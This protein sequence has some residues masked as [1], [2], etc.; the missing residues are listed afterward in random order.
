MWVGQD[1]QGSG[2]KLR[3]IDRCF[4]EFLDAPLI[5]I[6]SL[7]VVLKGLLHA[8]LRA[9]GTGCDP[10]GVKLFARP[11]RRIDHWITPADS[12]AGAGTASFSI[13][14]GSNFVK[15]PA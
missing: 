13:S 2:L 8:L 5:L 7:Q 1:L 14:R 9:K 3:E 11:D 6:E 15:P 10:I 4:K 12:I